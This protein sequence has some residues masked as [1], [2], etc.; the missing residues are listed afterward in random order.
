MKP[1]RWKLIQELRMNVYTNLPHV[2]DRLM[3]NDETEAVSLML[4]LRVDYEMATT[5]LAKV[6]ALLPAL[7]GVNPPLVAELRAALGLQREVD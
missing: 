6:E 3:A 2:I 1:P 4:T 5:R 7:D